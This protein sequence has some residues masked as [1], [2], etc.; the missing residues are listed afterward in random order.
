MKRFDVNG[1]AV[2]IPDDMPDER[3]AALLGMPLEDYQM[4]L[5]PAE[6]E[7]YR[8]GGVPAGHW[9]EDPGAHLRGAQP[10]QE[11]VAPNGGAYV[12]MEDRAPASAA[13]V[14][15]YNHYSKG[16][17]TFYAGHKLG[18]IPHPSRQQQPPQRS[19]ASIGQPGQAPQYA[20]PMA[21][22]DQGYPDPMAEEPSTG[23][24]APTDA[25]PE[26]GD[27]TYGA[28]DVSRSVNGQGAWFGN[29]PR[30]PTTVAIMAPNGKV[31]HIPREQAQAAIA[32]GGKLVG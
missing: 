6:G 20:Q 12:G 3:A 8:S 10:R 13:G 9:S 27:S 32:A 23:D 31:K 11:M 19:M 2:N 29:V 28:L 1:R 25:V 22:A 16:E 4:D 24:E 15:V 26:D 21:A 30:V 5:T 14:P 17:N 18:W 7:A